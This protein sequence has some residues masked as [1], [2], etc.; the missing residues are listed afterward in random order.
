MNVNLCVGKIH[1]HVM[2]IRWRA[3][4]DSNRNIQVNG[5]R[6]HSTM[7][8]R[9]A[10]LRDGREV[11]L[12]L[13]EPNDKEQLLGMFTRFSQDALMWSNPP[14]DEEKISRWMGGAETGLSIV[15]VFDNNLVGIAAIHEY[16]RPRKKGTGG[17]VIYIHQDFLGVGLG[18]TMTKNLLSIAEK[19]GLH[20]IGLWVIEDNKAAVG[21]YRKLGFK[22]EGLLQDAYFG[23]DGKYHNMLVMGIVFP[24][25]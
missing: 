22:I 2:R 13:L 7:E 21:L 18:T 19:K 1:T 3:R 20:R 23:T 10:R 25:N 9:K 6:N 12:R 4:W 24:E 16:T 15:A 8:K 11:T 5:K 17:M 14:Y